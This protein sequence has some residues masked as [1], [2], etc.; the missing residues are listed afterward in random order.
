MRRLPARHSPLGGDVGS[1]LDQTVARRVD[2]RLGIYPVH[3]LDELARVGLAHPLP[4]R[5]CAARSEPSLECAHKSLERGVIQQPFLVLI[6]RVLGV[7][8]VRHAVMPELL[9]LCARDVF[10]ARNSFRDRVRYE[11]IGGSH[12]Q[13]C[14]TRRSTLPD[15]S[16]LIAVRLPELS[17]QINQGKN[18]RYSRDKRSD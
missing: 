5:A 17:G 13:I 7:A 15:R 18:D 14:G 4:Y 2:R 3:E 12:E 6:K 8:D 11:R 1:P 9:E 10:R 16:L